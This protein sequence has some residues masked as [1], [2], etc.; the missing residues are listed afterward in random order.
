MPG[1]E[2]GEVIM[3]V[4]DLDITTD[5]ELGRQAL[6]AAETYLREHAADSYKR[7][8]DW[9]ISR[10]QLLGL[11]QIARNEPERIVEF[12]AKQKEKRQRELERTTRE[13]RKQE[14]QQEL[15]FWK[16]IQ[17]LCGGQKVPWFSWS[18]RQ[19]EEKL[20]P[21]ELRDEPLA[22]GT[23]L[24]PEQQNERAKR[25][26][27]REDWLRQWRQRYYPLFFQR[28]TIHLLYRLMERTK[29]KGMSR[30]EGENT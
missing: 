16:L 3:N 26:K 15:E 17:G 9:P 27:Q 29:E 12:A 2:K 23:K 8:G 11:R 13:E 5:E 24:T 4:Y 18:M 7:E 21:G 14:I 6:D 10:A 20:I 22:P 28:F 25:K 30:L 19:L 1:N